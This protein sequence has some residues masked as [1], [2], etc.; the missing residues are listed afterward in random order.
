[1]KILITTDW[2]KSAVNGVVTSVRNLVGGLQALGHDVKI[3]TLSE[4]RHSSTEGIVTYIGSVN[5]EKIY[6]C[7]RIKIPL[8][9]KLV[10]K[11]VEWKPDI[12]HSQCEFSTFSL[13]K[14]V[15]LK[16]GAPIVHTYH[17]IY[18]DYTHYFSP[19]IKLGRN[20]VRLFTRHIAESVS[21]MVAPTDKVRKILD[22][23]GVTKPVSVI[24]T[25]LNLDKICN[26]CSPDE[27]TAMKNKLGIPLENKVV[28]Y[29]GRLAEEKNLE[30][31]ISYLGKNMP[32]HCTFLIVGGGPYENNIRQAINKN[33]L[34]EMTIMT[35]MVKPD[36]IRNYYALGDIFVSA[37]QSETQGLTY[38][39]AMATGVPLLCRKDKC[40]ENV[41]LQGKNG[42]A[43]TTE[44]E[45]YTY[46]ETLMNCDNT[47]MKEFCKDYAQSQFSSQRFAES[48][49]SVYRKCLINHYQNAYEDAVYAYR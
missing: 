44:T 16:T 24:P 15:S 11:I 22:G 29:A 37:S 10:N 47:P 32:Q 21:V 3:L 28:M 26:K 7:A 41:L 6:P 39:E 12:I 9:S 1:M 19:S 43:Y 5:A 30:E 38:I 25:G 13:A 33:G 14:A 2:Y 4:N 18:E 36:E 49:E 20:A 35:G 48:C 46:L 17:T 23:Y 27:I 8:K 40:L 45:F 31:I 42:Y 34:E